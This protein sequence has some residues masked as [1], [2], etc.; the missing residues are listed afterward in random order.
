MLQLNKLSRV[1]IKTCEQCDGLY[2]NA[3]FQETLGGFYD[4]QVRGFSASWS[5]CNTTPPQVASLDGSSLKKAVCLSWELKQAEGG[6][7][8]GGA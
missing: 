8:Q 1:E 7:S 2:S 3:I 4:R 5:I 6:Q